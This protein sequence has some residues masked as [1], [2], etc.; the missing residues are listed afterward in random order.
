[1][2]RRSY[3][4]QFEAFHAESP[5]V[6]EYFCKFAFE[7]IKSGFK[8]YSAKGIVERIRWHVEVET[9]AVEEFKINNNYTA[10]YARKFIEDHPDHEGFFSMRK[11]AGDRTRKIQVVDPCHSCSEFGETGMHG[12]LCPVRYRDAQT[13]VG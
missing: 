2:P 11:S 5:Q 7:A 13:S 8:S 4:T 1:M 10:Y 3:R 12:I 9:Q 6:Y